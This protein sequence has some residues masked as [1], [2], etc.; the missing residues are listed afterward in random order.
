MPPSGP[1]RKS[2][3]LAFTDALHL[4][5]EAIKLAE[6]GLEMNPSKEDE[7]ALNETL[8]NLERKR[9]ELQAKLD[10][11]ISQSRQFPGPTAQQVAEVSRLTREVEAVTNASITASRAVALTSRVLALATEVAAG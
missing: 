8:G 2:P 11:L 4:V 1:T 5:F 3:I 9:A 10:A 7:R 6:K